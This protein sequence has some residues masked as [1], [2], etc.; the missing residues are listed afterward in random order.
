MVDALL[1]ASRGE[2]K[3]QVRYLPHHSATPSPKAKSDQTPLILTARHGHREGK[4]EVD[5]ED[6]SGNTTLVAATRS[7]HKAIAR[8]LVGEK[9]DAELSGGYGR[10]AFLLAADLDD[11]DSTA[12]MF[13]ERAGHDNSV[14]FLNSGDQQ[15]PEEGG[16]PVYQKGWDLYP[17]MLSNFH[18]KYAAQSPEGTA[19][20]SD[21]LLTRLLEAKS[22][23]GPTLSLWGFLQIPVVSA[24]A[25]EALKVET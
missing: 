20:S 16:H 4:A 24:I 18:T 10:T 13:V 9:C 8:L 2:D 11:D 15:K 21:S 14:R 23:K 5:V 22:L 3:T 12:L 17:R 6:D 19:L 7:D 1:P 25:I